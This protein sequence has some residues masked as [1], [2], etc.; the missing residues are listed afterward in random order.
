MKKLRRASEIL[1]RASA[2][3][4]QAELDRRGVI[5]RFIDDY[6]AEYSVEPI[7]H[8]AETAPS[9]DLELLRGQGADAEPRLVR[10]AFLAGAGRRGRCAT[11]GRRTGAYSVRKVWRQLRRAGTPVAPWR[12]ARSSGS[13]AS[14][15]SPARC[16]ATACAPWTGKVY[17]AF[18]ID[19]L[20]RRIVGCGPQ[21][22][23]A[24]TSRST[25]LSERS[26]PDSRPSGG[27]LRRPRR[28]APWEPLPLVDRGGRYRGIDGQS[29]TICKAMFGR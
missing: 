9:T 24:R 7:C 16:A 22:R 11:C 26:P 28:A 14:R 6:R 29:E 19:V 2:R 5:I 20:S 21:R 8:L 10:V 27:A 4:A 25:C 1:R 17:V 18:V 15:G 3:F 12:A 23:C 13:C